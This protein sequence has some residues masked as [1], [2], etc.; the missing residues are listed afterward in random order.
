M[1]PVI[2]DRLA[3]LAEAWCQIALGRW[4]LFIV[5]EGYRLE[6]LTQPPGPEEAKEEKGP[7][8]WEK[9]THRA[10]SSCSDRHG[11]LLTTE[12]LQVSLPFS[13]W[14]GLLPRGKKGHLAEG[15]KPPPDGSSQI[16]HHHSV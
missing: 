9:K 13:G 16:P 7:Q 8:S 14:G 3:Q 1:F 11:G 2:Q 12:A 5:Q 15:K 4:V 6:L 10:W